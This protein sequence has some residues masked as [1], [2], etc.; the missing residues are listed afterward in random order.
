MTAMA[1][2]AEDGFTLI[3]VLAAVVLLAIA[4]GSIMLM[5]S[6][7]IGVVWR[8][9]TKNQVLHAAEG[10]MA[11]K[12]AVGTTSAGDQL[13][14]TFHGMDSITVS[15]KI[16]SVTATER[17]HSFTIHAFIPQKAGSQP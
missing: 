13:S 9:G 14:F 5:F 6:N 10:D 8:T 4:I 17:G 1:N 11:E 3:E 12:T 15:G 2:R 7:G 16:E